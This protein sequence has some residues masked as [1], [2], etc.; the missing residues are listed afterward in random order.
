M[1]RNHLKIALRH[2]WRNRLFTSLNILGLA[3]GLSATWIIFRIVS[4]EF[5]FDQQ[6]PNKERVYRVVSQFRFESEQSGNP[7]IPLPLIQTA[8][9]SVPGIE[10]A[11]PAIQKR[12]KVLVPQSSGKPL[13]FDSQRDLIATNAGYFDLFPHQW[14]A[15]SQSKNLLNQ[16]NEV[17]LARSRAERYFSGLTPEQVI[18]RTLTYFD[19]VAVTVTGVVADLPYLSSFDNKEMLSVSTLHLKNDDADWGD[20]N[21]NQQLLLRLAPDIKPVRV[22]RQLSRIS[23]AKAAAALQQFGMKP[24]DRWHELQPLTDVHFGVDFR[25]SAHRAN[26]MVL[27]GLIGLALFILLLAIINYVNLASAQ[28]PQRAREIGIR[29]ALGSRTRSLIGQFMGETLLITILALGLAFLLTQTVLTYYGD[30]LP[31][32]STDYIDWPQVGLFLSSLLVVVSLLSGWYPGWLITRFQ[33]VAVLRGQIQLTSTPRLTLRKSLIVFQFVIAQVFIIGA[34][35]M[36]QQLSYVLN[37]D[38]GFDRDAVV[39]MSVPFR[40]WTNPKDI[41]DKEAMRMQLVQLPGVSAV[42]LGNLPANQSFSSNT[43]EY[44]GKTGKRS[45]DIYRKYVDTAFVGLYR[46]PLL[47]GRTIQASDTVREFVINE[48]TVKA[49]GLSR[50]QDAIGQ[51][52]RENGGTATPIVGVVRDFHI[53]SFREKVPPVALMM[54][55]ANL[56][57]FNLRLASKNPADWPITLAQVEQRWKQIY[58]DMPFAYEFYDKTIAHFYEEE[59]TTARIINLATAVAILL[60]CLGLFGLATLTA[61]Q[62]TKE[63]GIRKVLGAS[64]AGIVALLSKDFL[65][66]VLI[67]LVLAS[68]L[69]WWAVNRWLE[70]YA[71]KISISPWVFVGAGLLAVGIALLTVSYQS[72]KA[73]I[74]NPVNSIRTE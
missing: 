40:G 7:G 42:S 24:N 17:V 60:S 27:Y 32:G 8:Q 61:F 23:S 57:Q 41:P 74:A 12:T 11:I 35:L 6:H 55:K 49:M 68:P 29:K 38:M 72:V 10:L 48:T 63:I 34:I 31:K 65:K 20:V 28:V 4:Y 13:S 50:P 36:G 71:Y 16:P 56:N 45:F 53:L 69:A 67:A 64:V 44:T 25:E 52:I 21:N 62:R 22:E 70:N 54:D 39:T 58:P 18:G 2:L 14:L 47:A 73:A 15:G 3:I 33:P 9:Q 51:V 26:R 37:H 46:M 1:L 19:S 30:L 59:R 43:W 66:L 5:A